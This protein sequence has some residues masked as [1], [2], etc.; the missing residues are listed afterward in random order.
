MIPIVNYL[1]HGILPDNQKEVRKIRIKDPQY[2]IVRGILYRKVFMTPWLRCM[3]EAIGNKALHET[4]DG[5][6]NAHE[7]ARSLTGKI[8]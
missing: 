8:L 6:A 7:G 2:T 4:R 3:D 5:P 1:Q